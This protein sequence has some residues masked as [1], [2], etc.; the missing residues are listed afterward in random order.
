LAEAPVAAQADQGF[1]CATG[2]LAPVGVGDA[3]PVPRIL[4]YAV[5]PDSDPAPAVP[6][7]ETRA[8]NVTGGDEARGWLRIDVQFDAAIPRDCVLP[9]TV[10][11]AEDRGNSGD[12]AILN[13]MAEV[14]DGF[15]VVAGRP[16]VMDHLSS[17]MRFTG[18]GT[19]MA[20]FRVP[21][22]ATSAAR[23]VSHALKLVLVQDYAGGL[24]FSVTVAPLPAF[25]VVPPP[26]PLAAGAVTL[27]RAEHPVALLPGTAAMPVFFRLSSASLGRWQDAPAATQTELRGGWDDRFTPLR[28]EA[29]LVPAALSQ[30]TT[31]TL[32]VSF[33]GRTEA[34][35]I[36]IAGAPPQVPAPAPVTACEPVFKVV[37]IAG[38]LRLTMVNRV[39][40]NCPVQLVRPRAF[41]KTLAPLS[42][43]QAKLALPAGLKPPG[44]AGTEG[45]VTFTLDKTALARLKPGTRFEFDIIAEDERLAKALRESSITLSAT[46]IAVITGQQGK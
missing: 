42:P 31:G 27:V 9:L 16:Q 10:A 5:A 44:G 11:L 25:T 46:D 41:G 7:R 29:A 15:E 32:S 23:P 37:A 14:F 43:P 8:A 28:G 39:R 12:Q 17:A 1:S 40:G 21:I 3:R 26:G 30:T 18:S 45:S 33:A 6:L 2:R 34:A 24:P 20:S 22:R 38:G 19:D 35:P 4:R 13:R 36:T